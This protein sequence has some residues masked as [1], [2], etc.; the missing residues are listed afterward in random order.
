M[1]GK[2]SEQSK[3]YQ[4][5]YDERRS[6]TYGD[7]Y[8]VTPAEKK[9]DY[10]TLKQFI[11]QHDLYHKKCLE[12]GSSG[13]GFQDIIE[14]Y[15]GTDVAVSLASLYHK[16]FAVAKDGRFPFPDAMFDAIWTINTYEHIPELQT[17]LEEIVR[18]LKPGGVLLFAPAWQCRPWA[19]DGYAVRPYKDLNWKGILIKASLPIRDSVL[20]RALFIMPKRLYR[21]LAFLFG[22]RYQTIRYRRLKPNYEKYWTSDSDACN[23]IDPHD[24]ILWFISHE[25]VCL[26]Q[27]TLLRSLFFRT[28]PLIFSK[29]IEY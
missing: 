18:L 5:F 21:T 2:P 10:V 12:I 26:S 3:E 4:A 29:R 25:F 23:S 24:C 15:Y 19:A 17:A 6:L 7:A 28:G 13:G 16:P 27:N 14:D 22:V 1:T 9:S 20:W 11:E 8:T